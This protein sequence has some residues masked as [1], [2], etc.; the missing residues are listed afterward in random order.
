M[1][2]YVFYYTIITDGFST[3]LRFL[4]KDLVEEEQEKK[5]KNKA[6]KKALQGLSKQ[7][8]DK[9]KEEK[10]MLQIRLNLNPP[11]YRVP[12]CVHLDAPPNPIHLWNKS[13]IKCS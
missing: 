6:G 13:R 3:S 7:Q 10:I 5:N 8:K 11:N 1:K 4:H 9:I 12:M 2:N